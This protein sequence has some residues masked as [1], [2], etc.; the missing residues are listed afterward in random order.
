MKKALRK[1]FGIS[2]S[3]GCQKNGISIEY[4]D[5][6]LNLENIGLPTPKSFGEHLPTGKGTDNH[7]WN[8]FLSFLKNE[9]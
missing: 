9:V 6:K 5:K 2:P 3:Q 7:S 4:L 8:P 1:Q